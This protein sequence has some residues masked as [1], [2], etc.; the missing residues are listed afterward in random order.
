MFLC[1]ATDLTNG[2]M[3]KP[4]FTTY[5]NPFHPL[6]VFSCHLAG[7][8]SPW[9]CVCLWGAQRCY[10]NPILPHTEQDKHG[11][12]LLQLCSLCCGHYSGTRGC[13]REDRTNRLPHIRICFLR[14]SHTLILKPQFLGHFPFTQ[15]F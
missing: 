10:W 14:Y 13:Q 9:L 2:L 6:F 8:L 3:G 4:K 12:L 7:F 5:F 11:K 15:Y 1:N